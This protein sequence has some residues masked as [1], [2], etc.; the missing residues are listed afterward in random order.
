M[1]LADFLAESL[2]GTI[3]SSSPCSTSVGTSNFLRS[4]VKS[5][6][7]NALTLSYAFF[8]LEHAGRSEER[9]DALIRVL[10]SGLH[11]PEPELVEDALGDFG[12]RPVG[13]I[14]CYSKV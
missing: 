4:A 5:V 2:T 10:R 3:W 1:S 6:S 14:E 12:A 7:E 11:A 9:L 8:A 13:S